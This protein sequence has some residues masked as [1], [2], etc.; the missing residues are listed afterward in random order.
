MGKTVLETFTIFPFSIVFAFALGEAF[1]QCLSETGG[2]VFHWDRTPGLLTFLVL[3]LPFYQGMNRYLLLTYGAAQAS[4][5]RYSAIVVILDAAAFMLQCAA[6]F[7]MSRNLANARWRQFYGIILFLLV[8]DS[9][10]GF[11]SLLHPGSGT[12]TP[13]LQGWMLLNVAFSGVLLLLIWL[14]PRFP[15][16]AAAIA[17]TL[18]ML[19]RTTIDYVISWNFYFP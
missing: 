15:N 2:S 4:S 8:A 16:A 19:A 5:Q 13:V 3:I 7:A 6:F 17:G 9:C 12:T 14:G 1:K 10:W 11:S 18:A